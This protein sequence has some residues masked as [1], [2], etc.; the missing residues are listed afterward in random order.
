M[1]ADWRPTAA[2]GALAAPAADKYPRNLT[3]DD[4]DR[5]MTELSN[6][7]RWGKEDERGALLA[8]LGHD[9]T[10]ERVSWLLSKKSE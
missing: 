2:P 8:A 7:G 9:L 10:H 6:W 1:S 4:I 5:W 3:K